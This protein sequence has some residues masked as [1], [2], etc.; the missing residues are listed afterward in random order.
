MTQHLVNQII[1]TT[2]E[3]TKKFAFSYT[4]D[5]FPIVILVRILIFL[6]DKTMFVLF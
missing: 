1:K 6:F 3:I 4:Q 2:R 5:K